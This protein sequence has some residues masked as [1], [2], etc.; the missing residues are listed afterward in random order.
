MK[1]SETTIKAHFGVESIICQYVAYSYAGIPTLNACVICCRLLYDNDGRRVFSKSKP[2]KIWT[3]P[4]YKKGSWSGQRYKWKPQFM[5]PN[6]RF[7]SY[8]Y[9]FLKKELLT[10]SSIKKKYDVVTTIINRC[11][12]VV[13]RKVAIVQSFFVATTR[14][15]K[16]DVQP[17]WMMI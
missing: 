8:S 11:S 5:C 13:V 10:V 1:L 7:C 14:T 16:K 2:S 3:G 4:T 15:H 6:D 17:V 12:F 9:S